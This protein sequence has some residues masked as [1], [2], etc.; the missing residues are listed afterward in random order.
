MKHPPSARAAPPGTDFGDTF[1]VPRRGG[2]RL[3]DL[4]GI[5]KPLWGSL[6]LLPLGEPVFLRGGGQQRGERRAGGGGVGGSGAGTGTD[7]LT[8]L[9]R[10]LMRSKS[11][12]GII[13]R[14]IWFWLGS[15]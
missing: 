5:E 12:R 13:L 9:M 8:R 14:E 2:G 1:D 3:P 4:L 11:M 7:P 15:T 10:A 6:E